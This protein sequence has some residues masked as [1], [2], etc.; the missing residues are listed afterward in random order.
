MQNQEA[1]EDEVHWRVKTPL[2]ADYD[3][4]IEGNGDRLEVIEK[5]MKTAVTDNL[6]KTSI[7]Y[8]KK[9]KSAKISLF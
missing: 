5:I 2:E 4:A 1:N 6:K 3:A 9:S 7:S 8:N